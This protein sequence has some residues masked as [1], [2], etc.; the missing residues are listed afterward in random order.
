MVKQLHGGS[1][2]KGITQIYRN[3]KRYMRLLSELSSSLIKKTNGLIQQV[4]PYR[5]FDI[6]IIAILILSVYVI[7]VIGLDIDYLKKGVSITTEATNNLNSVLL[8]LSYSYAAGV[9]VYILTA[10]RPYYKR[11]RKFAD[12][13]YSRTLEYKEHAST[14][15]LYTFFEFDFFRENDANMAF[16][17]SQDN[18]T[19]FFVE[20]VCPNET[21]E[22]LD[23]R[24][25]S[26]FNE[27]NILADFI[28]TNSDFLPDEI[29][30]YGLPM[31]T[32]DSETRLDVC[33]SIINE[34]ALNKSDA[35]SAYRDLYNLF[36]K[37]INNLNEL[38]H[39][40]EKYTSKKIKRKA[41][42]EPTAPEQ[43]AE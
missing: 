5:G 7:L 14:A 41:Q 32:A 38:E 12:Y 43:L 6:V 15:S 9:F 8:N 31:N 10:M 28:L 36:V 13:I 34:F 27:Q 23:E 18:L 42:E 35:V 16:F 25:R 39:L 22:T 21:F 11:R 29:L 1:I 24:S 33:L 2:L 37:Y 3:M 20:R 26:T 30:H 40:I 4:L 19:K 17:E